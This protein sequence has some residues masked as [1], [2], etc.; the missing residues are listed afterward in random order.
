MWYSE[1]MR[2]CESVYLLDMSRR[3]GNV[4]NGTGQER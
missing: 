2:A 4:L 1:R 3:G